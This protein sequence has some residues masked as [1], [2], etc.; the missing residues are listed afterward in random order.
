MEVD[1]ADYLD[2]LRLINMPILTLIPGN[3]QIYAGVDEGGTNQIVTREIP[4]FDLVPR[5]IEQFGECYCTGYPTRNI[6]EVEDIKAAKQ[7]IEMRSETEEA[8]KVF[9]VP[10]NSLEEAQATGLGND[11]KGSKIIF[12]VLGFNG[13]GDKRKNPIEIAS[14]IRA[15]GK[16][17]LSSAELGRLCLPQKSNMEEIGMD[18]YLDKIFKGDVVNFHYLSAQDESIS[19]QDYMACAKSKNYNYRIESQ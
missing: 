2:K 1:R 5:L 19:P 13:D 4:T 17:A 15:I 18:L 14:E 9:F 16:N 6:I 12:L 11:Y 7:A 10:V 8:F 3:T